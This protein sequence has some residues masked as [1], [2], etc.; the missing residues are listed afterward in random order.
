MATTRQRTKKPSGK[1]TN[2]I[3]VTRLEKGGTGLKMEG[4]HVMVRISKDSHADIY[5]IDR[6]SKQI[7]TLIK[8]C[9]RKRKM[10][11]L[12]EFLAETDKSLQIILRNHLE[13]AM[14]KY[15]G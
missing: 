5:E 13:E 3:K 2:S 12:V 4:D 6:L 11:N 8:T 14:R 1:R 15:L 9:G 7:Q 10:H